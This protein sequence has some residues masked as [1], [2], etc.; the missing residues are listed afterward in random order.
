M[1]FTI[2]DCSYWNI[3]R[4]FNS[5]KSFQYRIA[6][7]YIN[8]TLLKTQSLLRVTRNLFPKTKL[9]ILKK[10]FY[11]ILFEKLLQSRGVWVLLLS[12]SKLLLITYNLFLCTKDL[13]FQ[14]FYFLFFSFR[15]IFS[16]DMNLIECSIHLCTNKRLLYKF[17][18]FAAKIKVIRVAITFYG[19]DFSFYVYLFFRKH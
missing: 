5:A 9:S 15:K 6:L 17:L 12:V 4:I 2:N 19:I 8:S 18:F 7:F 11:F 3:K 13:L 1:S 10:I 16:C 14:F